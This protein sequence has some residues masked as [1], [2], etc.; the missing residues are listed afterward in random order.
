MARQE[1]KPLSLNQYTVTNT[2][3]FTNEINQLNIN[4]GEILVS[5]DFS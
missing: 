3:D 5:Y 2:I 4:E 1:I